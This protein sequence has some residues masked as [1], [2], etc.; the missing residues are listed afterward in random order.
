MAFS[1][2]KEDS[3]IID[4]TGYTTDIIDPP[5]TGEASFIGKTMKIKGDLDSEEGVTIE[6]NVDGNIKVGKT[7]VIGKNGNASANIEAQDVC[8]F[9]AAKGTIKASHKLE[10]RT[11][12]RYNGSIETDLLVIED[13][14][15]LNGD[16]NKEK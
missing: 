8:I 16:V 4:S 12:G 6:G 7:L 3:D 1:I 9:G 15:I 10:I 2:K 14:A 11:L 5:T 13:G